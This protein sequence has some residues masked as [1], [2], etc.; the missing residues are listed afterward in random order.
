MAVVRHGTQSAPAPPVPVVPLEV[1]ELV[2]PGPVVTVPLEVGAPPLPAV[3]LEVVNPGPVV[4][5]EV[6]APP[7]PVLAPELQEA[8]RA[9][10][11]L[12]AKSWRRRG[13]GPQNFMVRHRRVTHLQ[14]QAQAG[15]SPWGIM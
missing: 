4:P 2:N 13:L 14:P 10:Q 15:R 3:P 7:V 6:G 12:K 1:V 5:E 9:T 11:L 8:T